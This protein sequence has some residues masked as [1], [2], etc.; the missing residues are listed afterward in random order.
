MLV[1]AAFAGTLSAIERAIRLVN[2][3]LRRNYAAWLSHRKRN[4]ARTDTSSDGL[5]LFLRV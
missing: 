3:H 5:L 2:Y 1:V 4:H